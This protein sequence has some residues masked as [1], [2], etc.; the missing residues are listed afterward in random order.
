VTPYDPAVADA[1]PAVP[2]SAAAPAGRWPLVG[3]DAELEVAVAHV[4]AGTGVVLRGAAGVGKSRLAAEV[5]ARLD[6]PVV[7]VFATAATRGVPLGGL[8]PL[9]VTTAGVPSAEGG[10]GLLARAHAA[11]AARGAGDRVHLVVDDVH[12]LDELSATVVLQA[13]LDGRVVLVATRRTGAD[14]PEPIARLRHEAGV[15]DVDVAPLDREQV[16]AV[17][18]AVLGGAVDAATL[19][20][21]W[22]VSEGNTLLLHELVTDALAR[23]VLVRGAHGWALD[24]A[25]SGGAVADAVAARLATTPLAARSGLDALAVAGELDLAHA[26]ELLGP[27]DLEVLE[28]DGVVT[29]RDDDR[30]AAVVRFAHPL[31]ADVLAG[32]LGVMARR[33]ICRALADRVA[34]GGALDDPDLVRVARWRVESGDVD[35]VAM[36]T[37]AA[38]VALGGYEYHDAAVLAEVVWRRAR[39]VAAAELLA[40]ALAF[41]GRPGEVLA[42]LAEAEVHAHT[43]A[44]RTR[45]AVRRGSA[46]LWSGDVEGALALNA[47]ARA[48]VTSPVCAAELRA[49]HATLLLGAARPADAAAIASELVDHAD[50]RVAL[51]AAFALAGAELHLGRGIDSLARSTEAYHRHAATEGSVGL[52]HPGIHLV[53]AAHALVFLGRAPEAATRVRMLRVAAVRARMPLGELWA[54]V[55]LG[56]AE[57]LMGRVTPATEWL[58]RA[59]QVGDAGRLDLAQGIAAAW[60]A[61]AVA[62]SDGGDV[63]AAIDRLDRTTVAI[64]TEPD[65]LRARAWAA[66][67]AGELTEARRILHDA[68]RCARSLGAVYAQATAWHDLVR[69]GDARAA[70]GPLADL[71]GQGELLDAQQR[72]AV[73]SAERSADGLA[74][75]AARFEAMGALLLAAEA[76]REL[77]DVARR[78]GDQRAGRAADHRVDVLRARCPGAATPGL[79]A[80]SAV[81]PLSGREREV[82]LLAAD[83]RSNR[84]IAAALVLSVRTVE[85]HLRG[86]YEKL[87]VAGRDDL[88]DALRG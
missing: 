54:S 11:L 60:S 52:G 9:L 27:A 14:V 39:T 4:R 17:L 19:T 35:D 18:R 49:H 28:D 31:Y 24:G 21:L 68:A 70:V 67:A 40:E 13:V 2:S 77:A 71:V 22:R 79:R 41:V 69:L 10:A 61:L 50:A 87:G 1:P 85:N 23:R 82:A 8:A 81:V 64:L 42:L 44:E 47:T 34:A 74:D 20:E 32:Q 5:A 7:T 62:Q 55:L 84:E 3:R 78:D 26:L 46:A 88:G 53:R 65:A 30:G 76:C 43:D 66:V 45:L 33:R 48:A 12:L 58:D 57:L 51:E 73:A 72:H 36:L 86:A 56:G 16:D 63:A 29:V 25:L 59:V 6:G 15:A 38:R 80:A 37:A 75:V 83:G